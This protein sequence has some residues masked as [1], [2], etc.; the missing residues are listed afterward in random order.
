M[1]RLNGVTLT[2]S[3]GIVSKG[4]QFFLDVNL[5]VRDFEFKKRGVD[6]ITCPNSVVAGIMADESVM[7]QATKYYVDIETKGEL[8]R[9]YNLV[10]LES[11]LGKPAN[12]RVCEKINAQKFQEQLVEVLQGIN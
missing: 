6:G 10:D 8:T 11:D 1:M 7:E 12:V 3:V 5:H 9:D 2:L 4:S